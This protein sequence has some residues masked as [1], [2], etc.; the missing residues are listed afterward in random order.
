MYLW[1]HMDAV[2]DIGRSTV[3]GQDLAGVVDVGH[4]AAVGDLVEQVRVA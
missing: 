4:S 1:R 3:R 2:A